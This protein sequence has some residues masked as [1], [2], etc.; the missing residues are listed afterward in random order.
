VL[1]LLVQVPRRR[2]SSH[3]SS[4][5]T[6]FDGG[7]DGGIAAGGR[8]LGLAS[9]AGRTDRG[10]GGGEGGEREPVGPSILA[11]SD[12]HSIS[13]S[14]PTTDALRPPFISFIT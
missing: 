10:N 14:V 3:N 7:F 4:R 5:P 11:Q 1:L 9:G 13:L 12:S 6:S 8:L 2:H